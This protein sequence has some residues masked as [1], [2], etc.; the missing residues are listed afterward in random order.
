VRPGG[1]RA[2]ASLV[3][4]PLQL[5]HLVGTAVPIVEVRRSGN[6]W[7]V[8]RCPFCPYPHYYGPAA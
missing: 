5:R 7:I 3:S 2:R 8:D 4:A 1:G 6:L